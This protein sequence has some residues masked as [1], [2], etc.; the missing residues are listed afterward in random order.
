MARAIFGESPRKKGSAEK[1]KERKKKLTVCGILR[2]GNDFDENLTRTGFRHV[3]EA[4]GE[5]AF[6]HIGSSL[7]L[8]GSH[9]LRTV[10]NFFVL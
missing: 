4:K 3:Y 9:C 2:R 10:R 8:D 1:K 5:P 6:R 7:L